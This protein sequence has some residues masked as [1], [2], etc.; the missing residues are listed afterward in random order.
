VKHHAKVKLALTVTDA[1][2]LYRALLPELSSLPT[3]RARVRLEKSEDRMLL[4]VEAEDL[5]V[6]RAVVNTYLRWI[7]SARRCLE[8]LEHFY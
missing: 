1:D 6:L 8:V 2:V 4:E 3:K 5:V 7:S